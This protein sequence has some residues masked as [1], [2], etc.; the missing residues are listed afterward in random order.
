VDLRKQSICWKYLF[1]THETQAPDMLISLSAAAEYD[2]HT[3]AEKIAQ[4]WRTTEKA[5]KKL[6]TL[7][8]QLGGI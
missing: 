6:L 3:R 4:T 5:Y 2:G 8:L 7:G 1:L